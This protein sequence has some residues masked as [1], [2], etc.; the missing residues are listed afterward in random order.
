MEQAHSVLQPSGVNAASTSE[1]KGKWKPRHRSLFREIAV[2]MMK[3]AKKKLSC[4]PEQESTSEPEGNLK[5][6][7]PWFE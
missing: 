5:G 4:S 3:K 1:M 6:K 2:C 7:V